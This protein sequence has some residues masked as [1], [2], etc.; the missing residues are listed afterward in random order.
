[1]PD[2]TVPPDCLARLE[3][4]TAI[5]DHACALLYSSQLASGRTLA[6]AAYDQLKRELL[7]IRTGRARLDAPDDLAPDL[8]RWGAES[9][10]AA[11]DD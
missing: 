10:A 4:A 7:A 6:R 2:P 3:A 5:L 9:P 11:L 1:M 8:A